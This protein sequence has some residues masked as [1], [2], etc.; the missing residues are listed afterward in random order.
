MTGASGVAASREDAAA[1]LRSRAAEFLDVFVRATL[2]LIE[3]LAAS[4]RPFLDTA[5]APV[6][7]RPALT[8]TPERKA[9]LRAL[10]LRDEPVADVLRQINGLAGPPIASVNALTVQV[11]KLRLRRPNGPLKTKSRLPRPAHAVR[12]PGDRSPHVWTAERMAL[13]ATSWGRQEP[14]DVIR[15]GLNHLAGRTIA[16]DHA[17]VVQAQKQGLRRVAPTPAP[18]AVV[19]VVPAVP[20]AALPAARAMPPPASSVRRFTPA[21]APLRVT[22]PADVTPLPADFSAVRNWASARGIE[23]QSRHDLAAVNSKRIAL[24]LRPFALP[25][26]RTGT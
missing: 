26:R 25:E 9:L 12:T 4:L 17:V 8:W 16:T 13:L 22:P 11:Q 23:M 18:I 10:W 2:P 15:R 1:D 14:V 6:H 3:G 20:P 7:G 24:G 21:P 19:S 5:P